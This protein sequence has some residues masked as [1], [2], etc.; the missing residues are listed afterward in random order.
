METGFSF[1]LFVALYMKLVL[2]LRK[3]GEC[4]LGVLLRRYSK[5]QLDFVSRSAQ[6]AT[7]LQWIHPREVHV[8][9]VSTP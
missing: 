5:Q 6:P 7:G 8:D 9:Y 3:G 1:V 4:I 2:V